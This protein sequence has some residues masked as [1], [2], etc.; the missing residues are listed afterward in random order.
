MSTFLWVTLKGAK[1]N[2][3][4]LPVNHG[5]PLRIV[6]PGIAG[7]RSVKW[8]DR[9]TVQANE[10]SNFYQKYDYKILPPEVTDKEIAEKYWDVIPAIQDMPINSVIA[11]PQ[12][13][14]TL[15]RSSRVMV[16]GYALPQ[17]D[18]GP[19]TRVEVS[20][21]GGIT[22]MD[23]TIVDGARDRGKWCWALWET[24]IT[25]EKGESRR[26][27]SR[28]TDAGGNVQGGS[29]EWNLRGVAYDG[30]GEARNLRVV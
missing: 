12:S 6:A 3:R 15:R 16:K 9:I 29:P 18:H 30:Y 13:G 21:D 23:A 14:E 5:F 7:A 17:G 26:I 11:M 2:G 22:W 8:L 1:M 10:S 24:E 19:V 27:L 20:T 28:A 25:L 4:P